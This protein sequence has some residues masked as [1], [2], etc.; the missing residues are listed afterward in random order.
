MAAQAV[1]PALGAAEQVA[2]KVVPAQPKMLSA[3]SSIPREAPV[4]AAP[5]I[6][7]RVLSGATA[8]KRD[9]TDE[10]GAIF[11]A[12]KPKRN[13]AIHLPDSMESSPI[14]MAGRAHAENNMNIRPSSR[15]SLQPN[16]PIHP[17]DQ[18]FADMPMSGGNIPT[19]QYPAPKVAPAPLGADQNTMEMYMAANGG[20]AQTP[21]NMSNLYNM[22]DR[23]VGVAQKIKAKYTTP[24]MMQTPAIT[25]SRPGTVPN[26]PENAIPYDIRKVA[27]AIGGGLNM[28]KSMGAGIGK[29]VGGAM[30]NPYARNAAV[31][32]GVAG[33]TGGSP[34]AGAAL[35]AGGTAINRA[36]VGMGK[37]TGMAS[38]VGG[39][40]KTTR[41]LPAPV[42]PANAPI[43]LSPGVQLLT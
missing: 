15:T 28:A 32:A 40:P 21:M 19:S 42:Q 5:S 10:N 37:N 12:L 3:V 31:G 36:M 35:G 9:L 8:N 29:A 14:A 25:P 23:G 11:G 4:A 34:L 27:L 7:D 22:N 18:R 17:M 38:L 39:A 30:K 2:Q 16:S 43:N 24:T 6:R 20:K 1:S 13:G 33:I 26:L 41:M